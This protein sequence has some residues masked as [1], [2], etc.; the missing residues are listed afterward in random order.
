M[1]HPKKQNMRSVLKEHQMEESHIKIQTGRSPP[2]EEKPTIWWVIIN[3][4]K[5]WEASPQNQQKGE[6]PITL[7]KGRSPPKEVE[8]TL[9]WVILKRNIW[10]ESSQG[11]SHGGVPHK[12]TKREESFQRSGTYNMM[13]HHKQ[14]EKLRGVLSKSTN[15]GV[16]NNTS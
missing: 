16:P 11:T 6:S 5:N 1:C 8:I 12:N 9:G 10:E 13:S 15:K 4:R 14:K 2:K 3:K 7:H